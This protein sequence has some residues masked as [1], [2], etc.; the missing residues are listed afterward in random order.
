[1][2]LLSLASTF[3]T[4]S[5]ACPPWTLHSNITGQC[6]CG[7]SLRGIV[8]CDNETL[9]VSVLYC[10]CMTYND[11]MNQTLI[12]QCLFMCSISHD[13]NPSDSHNAIHTRDPHQ[14]N[15]ET[16]HIFNRRGQL[17]GKCISDYG[18]AVYSYTQHCV[19][20]R[21]EDYKRNLLKYITVAF[22]PLTVF[23][24]LAMIFKL[25][26]TSG[27]MIAYILTCQIITSPTQLRL[28]SI[29]NNNSLITR[30][31]V[32]LYVMESGYF[33]F[34]VCTFLHPSE[35]EYTSSTCS[36]L[37]GRSLSS[38]LDTHHIHCSDVT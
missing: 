20:C 2:F 15:N 30:L 19:R 3:A 31:L 36:G 13:Q 7:N 6:Q 23:Y 14:I 16:C 28:V 17:C 35:T 38:F 21:K 10:Y 25:S 27:S 32:S 22:V 26:V 18:V 34:L 4:L 33:S 29:S 1:M 5:V 11:K 9:K 24:F 12:A 8:H 37:F